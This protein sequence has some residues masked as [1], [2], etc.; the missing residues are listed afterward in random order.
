MRLNLPNGLWRAGAGAFAGR[1]LSMNEFLAMS[2]DELRGNVQSSF[3]SAP[4]LLPSASAGPQPSTSG[5]RHTA[6]DLPLQ[7]QPSLLSGERPTV[8][9]AL[10]KRGGFA[11]S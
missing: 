4:L 6:L 3:G 7:R 1:M 11:R 5:R 10:S 2:F 9:D 8:V